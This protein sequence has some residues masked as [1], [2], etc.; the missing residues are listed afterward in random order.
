MEQAHNASPVPRSDRRRW[1]VALLPCLVALCLFAA[2]ACGPGPSEQKPLGCLGTPG[3]DVTATVGQPVQL[4][5]TVGV[6][7]CSAFPVEPGDGDPFKN[8]IMVGDAVR[9]RLLA[10]LLP[11]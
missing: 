9:L 2:V 1:A 6:G 3:S 4:K 11:V 7:S 8:D 10:P 5:A